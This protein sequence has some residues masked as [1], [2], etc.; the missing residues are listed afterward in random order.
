MEGM[1]TSYQSP[2]YE[3]SNSSPKADY[4]K[5]RNGTCKTGSHELNE[6][7]YG[8]EGDI[9][10]H[11]YRE[12]ERI[13]HD[14][15][16]RERLRERTPPHKRR[17]SNDDPYWESPGRFRSSRDHDIDRR[18]YGSRYDREHERHRYDGGYHRNWSLNSHDASSS[19]HP[20]L[21]GAFK[22]LRQFADYTDQPNADIGP[23]SENASRYELYK[24]D[25][26]ARHS[27]QFLEEH[28]KEDWFRER[29][30]PRVISKRYEARLSMAKQEAEDFLNELRRGEIN[31]SSKAD[32][33]EWAVPESA[34]IKTNNVGFA[35]GEQLESKENIENKIENLKN[36]EKDTGSTTQEIVGLEGQKGD[37]SDVATVDA[38]EQNDGVVDSKE[39][40]S[41]DVP[42]EGSMDVDV[43]SSK[44]NDLSEPVD[45]QVE[46]AAIY[47]GD[48]L[49][50]DKAAIDSSKDSSTNAKH[51]DTLCD[52]NIHSESLVHEVLDNME[53]DS[54]EIANDS[55][56]ATGTILATDS[57]DTSNS[58]ESKGVETSDGSTL[59]GF[60]DSNNTAEA[61]SST[62]ATAKNCFHE[63]PDAPPNTTLFIKQIPPTCSREE[64]ENLLSQVT[65]G[66]MKR[67]LMSDV[68]FTKNFTHIAWVTY[69]T[70]EAA[71]E[72]FLKYQ[73][74]K[75]TD[76]EVQ[77]SEHKPRASD[78]KT[79]ITPF[80]ASKPERL[81]HD[82]NQAKKLCLML[83]GEKSI[84]TWFSKE[85][86]AALLEN[87]T[88]EQQLDLMIL[89]LRRVH[90][91][92]YYSGEEFHSFDSMIMRAGE[93]YLR[94]TE[95]Y[96]SKNQN[97]QQWAATLDA[98]IEDRLHHPYQHELVT[99][100]V[101]IRNWLESF[102]ENNIVQEEENRA[103]CALCLKRFR[104]VEF[105]KKHLQIKHKEL[106]QAGEEEVYNQVFF[107]NYI[108]DPRRITP[109]HV[110]LLPILPNTNSGRDGR[111]NLILDDK[112]RKRK[113]KGNVQAQAGGQQRNQIINGTSFSGGSRGQGVRV[114]Q[115]ITYVDLDAPTPKKT[116][117]DYTQQLQ[118][119][120]E[121]MEATKKNMS[122]N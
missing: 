72:A 9:D 94:G 1:S 115:I 4:V 34:K 73:G 83:D 10:Y 44:S 38:E 45:G 65:T 97:A 110:A 56:K 86:N 6:R 75:L 74:Y 66:K 15:G 52:G 18:Y 35:K 92:C 93:L 106:I 88:V 121:K 58:S 5:Y 7:L 51:S 40:A 46:C 77:L 21:D 60:S 47:E 27:Q 81:E 95:N 19:P 105:V 24:Q 33:N 117:V 84:E 116:D 28:K 120:R 67:L 54:K 53:G 37:T 39:A 104:G 30:D 43:T 36:S 14:R 26:N 49:I 89:Y 22:S 11:Q 85:E 12:R 79:K 17:R 91:F 113:G 23:Q 62:S 101:G 25:Y 68:N 108:G 20:I 80:L 3:A 118:A 29:Y 78:R 96:H 98:K 42:K 112:R 70:P 61:I 107:N 64:L 31:F 57:I 100:Q 63:G 50:T 32:D 109:V 122:Q 99:G 48:G 8:R 69:T 87:R 82:L 16:Y 102:F 119:F 41:L 76:Y 103:H 90:W 2:N 55:E 114:R 111:R 13:A 71:S 59:T